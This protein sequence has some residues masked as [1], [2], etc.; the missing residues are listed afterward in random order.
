MG[1][2]DAAFTVAE[3]IQKLEKYSYDALFIDVSL[4]DGSGLDVLAF[5]RE[6]GCSSPALVLTGS[7]E[8]A[9]I[10][11]AFDL[12]ASY[13]IKPDIERVVGFARAVATKIAKVDAAS[14]WTNRYNL[15]ATETSILAEASEGASHADL[16]RSRNIAPGTLKAHVRNL[17]SK[18]GDDSLLAASARLLR[19]RLK[20]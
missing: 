17:L 7:Q 11:R 12:K 4:P 3:G 6:A 10:N 9:T 15:T 18:T 20:P 19:E 13:V 1:K 2:V 8:R 14:A 5:A 16:L